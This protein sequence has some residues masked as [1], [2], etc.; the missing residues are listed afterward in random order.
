MTQYT[1]TR[2]NVVMITSFYFQVNYERPIDLVPGIT[3]MVKTLSMKPPIFEIRKFLND[4]ECDHL[5]NL[6]NDTKLESSL[7]QGEADMQYLEYL[8]K[9]PASEFKDWDTDEN[10]KIDPKEVRC[11]FQKFLFVNLNCSHPWYTLLP[12]LDK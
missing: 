2:I 11:Y 6:A 3:H 7:T 10:G 5:I 12:H 1:C 8:T 4:S 9:P